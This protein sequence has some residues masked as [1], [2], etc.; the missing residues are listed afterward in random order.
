MFP[1]RI[2]PEKTA[3]DFMGIK[4]LA[5]GLSLALTIATIVL[6]LT[7]GLNFGID[8]TGGIVIE[9][10][11]TEAVD[12][13]IIRGP[14]NSAGLGEVSLQN[15]GTNNDILV[16]LGTKDTDATERMKAVEKVKTILSEKLGSNLD[17]RKVDFVGP[18]VGEELIKAGFLSLFLAFAAMMAYIWV[19]FEWQFG[20]GGIIAIFH[21]A[22]MTIGFFSL[23][24]IEFNLTSV[25]AILTII[26]YS[27]NDSVVIYDRIRENLRKYKKMPISE[28]INV[29]VNETL[30]RT[31][32]TAGTTVVA[33]AS[34]VLLGGDVIK[35]FSVS[36]L[37]GIVFG[38]YSSIYISAPVLIFMNLRPDNNDVKAAKA[39]A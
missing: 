11:S 10:R 34:L 24:G 16:R 6:L 37:F 3:I 1:L 39:A 19:R 17:Y 7:R 12:L 26:G 30:S 4:W 28:L 8:F 22:V 36:V 9:V 15:F 33:L 27:I 38:T 20:V 32:L 29:S 25:A 13:A 21:D 5:F 2:M 23:T 18:Q 35:G 31:I 14:L